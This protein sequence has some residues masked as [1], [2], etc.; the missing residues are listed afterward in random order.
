MFLFNYSF[1]FQEKTVYYFERSGGIMYNYF[2]I[3]F[4]D[5]D[6]KKSIRVE[7]NPKDSFSEYSICHE[8]EYTYKFVSVFH[9]L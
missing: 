2:R 1:L 7:P 3:F 5:D 9:S 4:V 6:S 8:L